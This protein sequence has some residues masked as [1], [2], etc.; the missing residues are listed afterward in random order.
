MHIKLRKSKSKGQNV[1]AQTKKTFTF[2]DYISTKTQ[3]F[4][5]ANK[6]EKLITNL[7]IQS[8]SFSVKTIISA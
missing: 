4:E 5:Y 3:E 1:Y 6:S 8:R 2:W 7:F